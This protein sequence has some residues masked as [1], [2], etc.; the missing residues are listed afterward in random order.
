LRLW[1]WQERICRQTRFTG[2]RK[3]RDSKKNNTEWKKNRHLH[4][5]G[6]R[7][8]SSRAKEKRNR[9]LL[10]NDRPGRGTEASKGCPKRECDWKNE[11]DRTIIR[12][13][14]RNIRRGFKE[15][16]VGKNPEQSRDHHGKKKSSEDP[17]GKWVKNM[18]TEYG[19]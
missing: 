17:S 6:R 2:S 7:S 4:A 13:G 1:G 11:S 3:M 19:K 14:G 12:E 15:K 8:H 9:L 5:K 16:Q 10:E 18:I